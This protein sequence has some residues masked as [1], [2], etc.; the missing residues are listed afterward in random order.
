MFKSILLSV[1][2]VPLF[3]VNVY[4]GPILKIKGPKRIP[5]VKVKRI[6]SADSKTLSTE[7]LSQKAAFISNIPLAKAISA[8]NA[9]AAAQKNKTS[10]TD[11]TPP[12]TAFNLTAPEVL[13]REALVI[14]Y[15]TGKVLLDKN[16][17]KPTIPSSMTKL[18]TAYYILKKLKSGQIKSD[19]MLPVSRT[20]WKTEGTRMFLQV[21][22]PVSVDDALKGIIIVSGNDACV[23]FGEY[24]SGEDRLF[25]DALTKMAQEIG[26]KNTVIKNSSGLPD[27]GHTSTM[28]DLALVAKKTIEDFPESLPIY[29][30][31]EFTYNNI[32]QGNRNPLLYKN[33]G[34]K[35]MKTGHTEAGG[36]GLVAYV[37]QNEQKLII[38]VNGLSSMQKRSDE[39]MKLVNWAMGAY[40]TSTL[41]SKDQSI[42]KLPVWHGQSYYVPVGVAH[43][44]HMTLPKNSQ[45]KPKISLEYQKPLQAPIN[46]GDKVGKIMITLGQET[47][48]YDLVAM[49]SVARAGFFKRISDSISYMLYGKNFW[50]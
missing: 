49:E 12:V 41:Y 37:E 44:I 33:V 43:D 16:G 14:D 2:L 24:E 50:Q 34:C 17:N 6:S 23:A 48:T 26:A 3:A 8:N 35:G 5:A 25:G 9:F 47:M 31:Q 42:E 40:Q 15:K 13:A 38:A 32:K 19:T 27:E 21:N 18:F 30:Q 46:K 22:H 10:Y 45:D 28:E 11:P 20:A 29:A 4:G 36:F 1:V 39:S 7:N